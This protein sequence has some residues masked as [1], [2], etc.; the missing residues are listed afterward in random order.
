MLSATLGDCAAIYGLVVA[1]YLCNI[2]D[3]SVVH[4]KMM[5]ALC[6]F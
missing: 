2:D 1:S 5:N 6:F 4:V 3:Y